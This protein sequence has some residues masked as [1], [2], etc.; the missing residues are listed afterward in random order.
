M[1][2][3]GRVVLSQGVWPEKRGGQ[4]AVSAALGRGAGVAMGQATFGANRFAA[5]IRL[6]P[7]RGRSWRNLG[8]PGRGIAIRQK[9]FSGRL[10]LGEANV[11]T[12]F[13]ARAKTRLL[14]QPR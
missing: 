5:R 11:A 10:L 13:V 1:W 12:V 14:S 3:G 7:Y 4:S 8:G 9:R 2:S 6:R